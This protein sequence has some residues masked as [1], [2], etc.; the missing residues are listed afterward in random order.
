M[1][2]PFYVISQLYCENSL[3]KPFFGVKGTLSLQKK[4]SH[5]VSKNSKMFYRLVQKALFTFPEG[6]ILQPQ[7]G[8]K[9]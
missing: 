1:E 5:I 9:L 8:Q 7:V 2:S 6:A 3:E 4:R